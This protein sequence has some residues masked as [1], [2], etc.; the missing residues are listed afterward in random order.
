[1]EI[2]KPKV[3]FLDKISGE[4]ILKRIEKAARTCYKSEH[5]ISVN[6]APRFVERLIKRGHESPLEHE[7]ITLKI[8]CD[9][10]ISHEIVRHRIGSYSQES[11]RYCNYRTRGMVFIEPFFFIKDEEK[12]KIWETVMKFC[13]EAYNKLIE[14]GAPP[15]EARTVLPHSLKTE[16][17][18]TYNLRQW[19][20][21]LRIRTPSD[22]HP[23]MRQIAIAILKTFH[24]RIPVIFDDI[25]MPPDSDKIPLAEVIIP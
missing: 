18:V 11:T 17:V 13:E 12:Y 4:E 6:S 10:G 7:K 3:I 15:Q 2:W 25:P 22:A 21:F 20:H 8:I 9:R 1:M 24:E 5:K 16:I 14:L 19:R 23:Q